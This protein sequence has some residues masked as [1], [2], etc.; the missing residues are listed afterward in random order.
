MGKG[1]KVINFS[2]DEDTFYK[3]LPTNIELFYNLDY[4]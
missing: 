1:K 2:L 3:I 4:S